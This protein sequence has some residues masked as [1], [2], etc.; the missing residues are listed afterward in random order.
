MIKIKKVETKK[1]L[2]ICLMIRRAV[3]IEELHIRD[4]EIDSLENS[5]IHFVAY[6][7]NTPTG[8]GKLKIKERYII[9]ERIA[10]IKAFRRKGIG[11]KLLETMKYVATKEY[12]LVRTIASVLVQSIPFYE[13]LGWKVIGKTFLDQN[14][15]SLT[16]EYQSKKQGYGF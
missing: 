13:K 5:S 15:R 3:F 7:N 4:Q 14:A 1:E 12:P 6:Y 8:T 2:E 9:M 16:M 10:I 11:K